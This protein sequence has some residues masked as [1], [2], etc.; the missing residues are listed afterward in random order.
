MPTPV[1]VLAKAAHASGRTTVI[2][3]GIGP[4][5]HVAQPNA[6]RDP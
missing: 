6:L 3:V 5:G 4:S 1:E 2:G